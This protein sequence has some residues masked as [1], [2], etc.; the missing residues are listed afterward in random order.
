MGTYRKDPLI[1]KTAGLVIGLILI[2]EFI[3][4]FGAHFIYR[5]IDVFYNGNLR[6]FL[7]SGFITLF[8][9]IDFLIVFWIFKQ[10]RQKAK[11][12]VHFLDPLLPSS[13]KLKDKKFLLLVFWYIITFL[14][15]I[16]FKNGMLKSVITRLMARL[17]AYLTIG[18]SEEFTFRV[19]FF[20]LIYTALSAQSNKSGR[21]KRLIS[22]IILTNILFALVHIPGDLLR[23]DPVNPSRYGIIFLIGMFLSAVLLITENFWIAALFHAVADIY[24]NVLAPY[25][26]PVF[27]GIILFLPV[28]ILITGSIFIKRKLNL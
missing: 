3:I 17:P 12:P 4:S 24:G 28:I 21:C 6:E 16:I 9:L 10:V 15:L 8:S 11:L 26:S 1:P 2:V 5:R 14:L 27:T 20:M 13:A 18:I 23:G 22:G 25:V 7:I 19:V